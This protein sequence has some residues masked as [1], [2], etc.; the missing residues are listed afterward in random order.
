MFA[1]APGWVVDGAVIV[2]ALLTFTTFLG[3]AFKSKPGRWLGRKI[4]GDVEG[5]IGRIADRSASHA[6]ER[7]R[8]D[9]GG[10]V[11]ARLDEVLPKHLKPVLY[12]LRSNG[13][14]SFRD[15]TVE[16]LKQIKRHLDRFATFMDESTMDRR[17]LRETVEEIQRHLDRVNEHL[18]E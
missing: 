8:A 2:G 7:H 12:E 13:G 16:Q 3:V 10:E 4:G 15:E 5:W 1:A 17:N 14:G 9:V 11:D 18:Q 6:L